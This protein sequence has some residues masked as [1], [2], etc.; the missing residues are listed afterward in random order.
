MLILLTLFS[1]RNESVTASVEP[2]S[3]NQTEEK[4]D[5]GWDYN[6]I[7]NREEQNYASSWGPVG[8]KKVNHPLAIMVCSES[9]VRM[10]PV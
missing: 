2:E 5:F 4:Q 9:P 8:F 6:A 7:V 1:T 3:G 10:I